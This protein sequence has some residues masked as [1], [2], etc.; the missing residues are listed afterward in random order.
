MKIKRNGCKCR[1]DWYISGR[2]PFFPNPGSYLVV[3]RWYEHN[4]AIKD[5]FV[6]GWKRFMPSGHFDVKSGF[7]GV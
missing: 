1:F 7:G 4:T 2:M 6:F 3:Q 5:M